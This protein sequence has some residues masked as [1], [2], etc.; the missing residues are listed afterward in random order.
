MI[1]TMIILV[2]ALLAAGLS[3]AQSK[4]NDYAEEWSKIEDLIG[5]RLPASAEKMIA[6]V[7]AK[8]KLEDNVPQMVR[9]V[10]YRLNVRGL[11]NEDGFAEEVAQ[12]EAAIAEASV[13]LKNILQSVTADFYW[14]YYSAN[15]WKFN[16][17]T[18]SD[19]RGDDVRTWDL[20]AIVERCETLY[21]ASV[22][23]VELLRTMPVADYEGMLSVRDSTTNV[24]RP[25]LW[26]LL[27]FRAVD[28]YGREE[29]DIVRPARQFT[30]D[31]SVFVPAT[32]FV[33]SDFGSTVDD[34]SFKL[35]ALRVLRSIIGFH[36]A[37]KDPTAL[38]DADLRR[39]DLAYENCTSKE[40]DSLYLGAL[41]KMADKYPSHSSCSEILYR[42][43][44]C[45]KKRGDEYDAYKNPSVQ[46][47]YLR[48]LELVAKVEAQYP[49][50][51]GATNCKALKSE[52][53]IPVL[54]VS[55]DKTVV[56]R[57]PVL[58]NVT[59]RNISKLHVR[60]IPLDV[61]DELRFNDDYTSDRTERIRAYAKSYDATKSKYKSIVVSLPDDGDRQ[62]HVARI[63]LPALD[64]GF[65]AVLASSDGAFST[66]SS[67]IEE[68]RIRVSSLSYVSKSDGGSNSTSVVVLNRESGKPMKGVTV[69]PYR[70]KYDSDSRRYK[71]EFSGERYLSDERG[72]VTVPHSGKLSKDNYAFLLEYG[73]DRYSDAYQHSFH[74]RT[75]VEPYTSTVF[76]LDRAIYRPGQTV[77]F[78]GLVMRRNGEYD[79]GTV[80]NFR[81]TVVLRN[82]NGEK[83]AEVETKSNEFGS[84]A[85]SFVIPSVGLTGGM[86]IKAEGTAS[87][88]SFRVE[89][90]KRPMFEVLFD[91]LKSAPRLGD[92]VRM[93]GMAR[94]Y[95]GSATNGAKVEWRVTR[96]T[97]HPLW[98]W[99]WGAPPQGSE[100]QI[101]F[102]A[103]TTDDKGGFN[104]EFTAA[105]D[106][107]TD[108][109]QSP[110]FRYRVSAKVTDVNGETHEAHSTVSVGYRSLIVSTDVGR[111]ANRD[112]LNGIRV[113]A[114]NLN[115][116]G[117]TVRGRASIVR[118][119]EPGLLLPPRLQSDFGT[120]KRPDRF[121]LSRNEFKRLFPFE[122]YDNEDDPETWEREETVMN[123]TFAGKDPVMELSD[124]KLWKQ[125]VYRLDVTVDDPEGGTV[126]HSSVF[127]LV[128]FDDPAPVNSNPLV[129]EVLNGGA[130]QPGDTLKI[131]VAT[132]CA[133][134]NAVFEFSGKNNRVIERRELTLSNSPQIISVPVTE[135]HRGNADVSLIFV[136]HNQAHSQGVTIKVPYDNKNLELEFASF[137]DKLQ[138]GQKEELRVT[139]K[140]NKGEAVV[141]ELLASMY[142]AS[143]DVF[144]PHGWSFAPWIAVNGFS[145]WKG[146][147]FGVVAGRQLAFNHKLSHEETRRYNEIYRIENINREYL[148]YETA[149]DMPENKSLRSR[150]VAAYAKGAVGD[151]MMAGNDVQAESAPDDNVAQSQPEPP[152]RVNFNETAFFHPQLRTD[153]NGRTVLSFTMP[154]ALTRWKLQALAWT[155][156][157]KTG[158]VQKE[159]VTQRDLMIFANVPRFFREG[160][161]IAFSA[162]LTVLGDP[163]RV[164]TARLEFFDALT[165]KP[166]ETTFVTDD[167]ERT[168]TLS[169]SNSR[170]MEWRI[171]IPEGPAAILYRIVASS[172]VVSDGEEGVIPVLSDRILVTETMPLPVRGKDA[173]TFKF[174]RLLKSGAKGSTLRNQSY[175]VEFTSNP[176][177]SAVLALP[178]VMEYP[179]ECAEQTF[180]RYYAN[181]LASHVASSDPKIK[182]VFDVW[183]S[184][185]PD[186]LKSN[187]DKNPQLK[188]VLTEETP[189]LRDA[190]DE[191]ERR[192]R[193]A[194]LF[195]L[196]RMNGELQSAMRKLH[197]AQT[198]NGGFAWFKGDRDDRYITQLIVAGF[199]RLSKL[200]AND[201]F[202]NRDV[203]DRAVAYLDARFAEDFEELKRAAE[204]D[205]KDY[206]SE[207]HLTPLVAHYLYARSFFPRNDG[208]KAKPA[209]E[210]HRAQA[211]RYWTKHD[212][213]V[214]GMLALALHRAGDETAPAQIMAS[215]SETAL[216]NEESGMWWGG[217]RDH[218]W[219]R[220]PVETQ[221][222]MIEAYDEILGDK[223]TVEE[224][225][226]WLL[227]QKQT[228]DWKTTKA[229]A[230]AV[231]A[232]LLRGANL[233]ADDRPH[234][235][236]VG[237]TTV[238]PSSSSDKRAEAGTGYFQTSWQGEAV[239]PSLGKITVVPPADGNSVAWGA[240]YWQYF[241][242]TDKI[243][244]ADAGMKIVKR[245]FVKTDTPT[246]ARLEAVTSDRPIRLG[247]RVTVR[248]EIT[249]DRDMEYV[250]LKDMRASAFEPVNSLS[251][252]R[253]QGSSGYYESPRDASVNFFFSRL[254]KG[255]H[256]LEYDMFATRRGNFSNGIP[257]IQCM[258]AP[259]FCAHG[260]GERVSVSD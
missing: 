150:S 32:E 196:A 211:T 115:G 153:E 240:A 233:L 130:A 96:A 98:R 56:P 73:A 206:A 147:S 134:A 162:K 217:E 111:T 256:V 170:A 208:G 158:Y 175:T 102:G 164:V 258:Y 223:S 42:I 247:D 136:K 242:R 186:A 13:P 259:E 58:A 176:A 72:R 76:F 228:S 120:A 156:D 104:L 122:V 154:D 41:R 48:A 126:E 212:T 257:T 51:M 65:Y 44:R 148:L 189:W 184:V 178:Y 10:I 194:T 142:D 179:H 62:K 82:V 55:A 225:K 69:K 230:D 54:N 185:Q 182:R 89:E 121:P 140:N 169:A 119:R 63:A 172:G 57:Q 49:G 213:Y 166:V 135:E 214:K 101:A 26:D 50:T 84:F 53:E 46:R 138:P 30:S 80:A 86:T 66:A 244:A 205:G 19:V 137:R 113:S 117:Q 29:S 157:L 15:R 255:V 22:A 7:Y 144:A 14:R 245:L 181:A 67:V 28:F 195:D 187:L 100:Q 12:L 24:F 143:L 146:S 174:D 207:E 21:A 221:A 227:K 139:V 177:W 215:L 238:T 159:L 40:R 99:W 132:A 79:A 70:L 118:L 105:P 161:T 222:L 77:Y 149:P 250:H 129:F 145:R 37:D 160:D 87:F 199:G 3:D 183:R 252:Y 60:I 2:F 188:S 249:A 107:R 6:E 131:L 248:L 251:G 190:G 68:C 167:K 216:R 202:T 39:L 231:Y 1:R 124:L 203:L 229:T 239:K 241:E 168:V 192:R 234:S 180:N 253:R 88:A 23:D 198:S 173:K 17:R 95:A 197:D 83:T 219:H 133:E 237:G 5:K 75:P 246:G 31:A 201:K 4:R 25:T 123:G 204:K 93:S 163:I 9:A 193:T 235:V 226:L 243:T 141:A 78:K 85:G 224:L 20:S 91:S 64:E 27:A 45:H 165:M 36:L 74:K 116:V 52:I 151:E 8:A 11:Y 260:K 110:V 152:L 210:F 106:D 209:L 114:V 38:I 109:K 90:Y 218:R 103:T 18:P 94:A 128:S 43:A 220:A 81:Q 34:D 127:R 112:R 236:T 47:E 191:A 16:N 108:A 71:V 59:Y 171:R 33:R 97:L 155:S 254:S 232:L 61:E 35:R 200:T 92:E 125:G